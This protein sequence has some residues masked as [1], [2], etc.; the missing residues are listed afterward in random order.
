M[1]QPE[2]LKM[3]E[4]AVGH[5]VCLVGSAIEAFGVLVIVAGIAWSTYRLSRNLGAA[6]RWPRLKYDG[7]C[8]RIARR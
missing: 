3:V 7:T 5:G 4:F 1:D 8:S 2:L 6:S